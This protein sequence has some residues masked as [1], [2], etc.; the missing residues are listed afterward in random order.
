MPVEILLST[1]SLSP[2]NENARVGSRGEDNCWYPKVEGIAHK[3]MAEIPNDHFTWSLT[4]AATTA[5]SFLNKKQRALESLGVR[6]NPW[7]SLSP[8]PHWLSPALSG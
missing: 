3:I 8:W 1:L 2:E 5:L 4:H 6:W 7:V